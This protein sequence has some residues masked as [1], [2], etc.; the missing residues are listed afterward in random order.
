MVLNLYLNLFSSSCRSLYIF[1]KL[2]VISFEMIPVD[3]MKAEHHSKEFVQISPLKKV[4]VMK[5][6]DF[7]LGERTLPKLSCRSGIRPAWPWRVA[8]GAVGR[9][10]PNLGVRDG[11]LTVRVVPEW[12]GPPPKVVGSPHPRSLQARLHGHSEFAH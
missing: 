4:P 11:F 8:P 9:R 2:H 5:D 10:P 3:L 6:E 7:V 12:N 1:A